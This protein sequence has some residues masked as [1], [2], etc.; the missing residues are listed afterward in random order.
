MKKLEKVLSIIIMVVLLFTMFPGERSIASSSIQYEVDDAL[1]L[2]LASHNML[3][4]GGLAM[5]NPRIAVVNPQ[6]IPNEV[7]ILFDIYAKQLDAIE[8]GGYSENVKSRL[9]DELDAKLNA[10]DEKAQRL[11]AERQNR[12]RRGFFRRFSRALGRATGWVLSKSMDL[13]GKIVQYS[14]EEVGPQL[15]KDA[16]FSGAPLTGAT[17][18]AKFFEMLRNRGW[19]VVSNKFETRAAMLASETERSQTQPPPASEPTQ[20][21]QDNPGEL[22]ETSNQELNQGIHRYSVVGHTTFTLE[23]SDGTISGE[24]TVRHEF[25][26]EGVYFTFENNPTQ[27]YPR[28]EENTFEQTVA[29]SFGTVVNTLIY[30]SEGFEWHSV[31][32]TETHYYC[33]IIR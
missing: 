10:L 5:R 6:S 14:I 15:I 7:D 16:V 4:D 11:E 27:F 18:R 29:G 32:A 26:T 1:L 17:F 20:M 13:S 9:V 30:T 8:K 31:G 25:T 3:M 2:M 22:G 28:I 12:R 21:V 19:N 23:G 24:N 33:T